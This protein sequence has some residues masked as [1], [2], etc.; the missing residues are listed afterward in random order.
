MCSLHIPSILPDIYVDLHSKKKIDKI[1]DV[2]NYS[3]LKHLSHQPAMP[4]LWLQISMCWMLLV[5]TALMVS[6]FPYIY[7]PFSYIIYGS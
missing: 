5:C 4:E 7:D 6:I 3:F 2:V 1:N